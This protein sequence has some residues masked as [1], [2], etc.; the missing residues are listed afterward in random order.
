MTT[1]FCNMQELGYGFTE[2][3]AD[4]MLCNKQNKVFTSTSVPGNG[5]KLLNHFPLEIFRRKIIKGRLS[6]VKNWS[7]HLLEQHQQCTSSHGVYISLAWTNG[8]Q[9]YNRNQKFTFTIRH[10]KCLE[11]KYQAPQKDRRASVLMLLSI[12]RSESLHSLAKLSYLDLAPVNYA[13]VYFTAK[14]FRRSQNTG[15]RAQE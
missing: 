11:K 1:H 13:F 14:S 2:V 3:L 12:S 6:E 7:L 8:D 5:K 4:S 9:L 15:Q 10:F